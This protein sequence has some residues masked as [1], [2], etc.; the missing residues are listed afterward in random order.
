MFMEGAELIY[1]KKQT[2]S[3][4]DSKN[5]MSLKDLVDTLY[6]CINNVQ[7]SHRC[8]KLVNQGRMAHPNLEHDL[9]SS[10]CEGWSPSQYSYF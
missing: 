2:F 7:R 6:I 4:V 5:S 8:M 1:E 10:G 3:D 9:L